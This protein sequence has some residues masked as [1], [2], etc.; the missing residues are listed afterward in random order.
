MTGG[1]VV[2]IVHGSN[3]GH[4]SRIAA[5][6]T[7]P[8][9]L[10]ESFA[11]QGSPSATALAARLASPPQVDS[12]VVALDDSV[13]SQTSECSSD[14]RNDV[15]SAPADALMLEVLQVTAQFPHV[16]SVVFSQVASKDPAHRFAACSMLKCHMVTHVIDQLRA[17]LAILAAE[18]KS[19]DLKCPVCKKDKM[20]K[21][22]LWTH[23]PMFHV[24]S[25]KK[26]RMADFPCPVC[27]EQSR[28]SVVVH[29]HEA[30]PPLNAHVGAEGR[31]MPKVVSFGL[32]VIQRRSDNKFLVVQEY[33]NQGFWLPGGGIDGA[34][35]PDVAAMR[36]CVEEAGIHVELTGILR[37]EVSPPRPYAPYMRMRYI[38]YGHPISE[39][40]ECKTF[41]DFESVG[42]CWVDLD[43]FKR[44]D[45][46]W[47][48]SEPKEWFHYVANGGLITPLGIL[49]AEGAPAKLITDSIPNP[50]R[51][52]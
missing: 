4:F 40:E 6:L 21:D 45:I 52:D 18:Q 26:L 49:T 19:G 39:E 12:V 8:G 1:R 23:L 31:T 44:P 5:G 24:N 9:Q 14:A 3:S 50:N 34:E 33:D 41:P 17:S 11:F 2:V 25:K 37:V 48:G 29:Y 27:N 32:C 30:H 7:L 15:A 13:R 16:F 51:A 42:A 36:E 28:D 38:F 35:M 22:D 10:I 43:D 47:R 46:P 20:T